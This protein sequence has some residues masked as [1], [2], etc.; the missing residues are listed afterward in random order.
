MTDD[1]QLITERREK[2]TARLPKL[3]VSVVNPVADVHIYRGDQELTAG[4]YGVELRS[5]CGEFRAEGDRRRLHEILDTT[6]T[7]TVCRLEVNVRVAGP[8][9]V[10]S[11]TSTSTVK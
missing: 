2:L 1:N 3:K 8:E 11:V 9:A 6:P 4:T 5:S 7:G 10:A